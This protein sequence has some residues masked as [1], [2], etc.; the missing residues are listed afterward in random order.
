MK[1]LYT[2]N[3]NC[4]F[5]KICTNKGN[6]VSESVLFS[7]SCQSRV[8]Q[9]ER[10]FPLSKVKNYVFLDF[11]PHLFLKDNSTLNQFQSILVFFV[12]RKPFK[13]NNILIRNVILYF[14]N[15]SKLGS[16]SSYYFLY[17]FVL[18]RRI[19]FFLFCIL[20]LF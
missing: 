18:R 15:R 17:Q 11:L 14:L 1:Q 7:F 20:K 13:N 2:K 16:R 8:E 6:C 4:Q 12:L 9:R 5:E 19:A 3:K 10:Q